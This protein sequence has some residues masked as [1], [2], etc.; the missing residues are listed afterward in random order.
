MGRGLAVALSRSAD[1][2]LVGPEGAGRKTLE[3][4]ATGAIEGST[5]VRRLEPFDRPEA[6]IGI[7]AV[8]AFDMAEACRHIGHIDR[9]LCVS[10]GIGFEEELS[11]TLVR[12]LRFAPLTYGFRRVGD[13]VEVS[14]GKVFI[15]RSS[16]FLELFAESGLELE[17]V[18]NITAV[19][20]AKWI[21]NSVINPLGS[22][23]ALPNNRL[24][25]AGLKGLM[26][27]LLEELRQP[28][29][30]ELRKEAL[31]TAR[32]MLARLLADSGNRCSMLQDIDS[33]RRTEVDYL[34]GLCEK[35]LP[36][37]CPTA[38]AL[39]SLVRALEADHS[40]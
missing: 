27:Q 28:V 7:L 17:A 25:G 16:T 40:R 19:R 4:R 3:L 8:K 35:R 9:I 18:N 38:Y 33:G 1:V 34:T 37:R 23:T 31:G 5:S 12:R 6:G 29:P 2:T 26:D 24:A 22:L 14:A 36:G 10:N 21:V 15:Q 20:W 39:S 11:A 32:A 30:E 13:S